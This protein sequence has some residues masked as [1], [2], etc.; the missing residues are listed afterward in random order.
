MLY[1]S[2]A[3][4]FGWQYGRRHLQT[5]G[6]RVWLY[7]HLIALVRARNEL[8]NDFGY[9]AL[10]K[11]FKNASKTGQLQTF[12]SEIICRLDGSER[13]TAER[14]VS[15]TLPN[16]AEPGRRG[17][18]DWLAGKK[19]VSPV[20]IAS[21]AFALSSLLREIKKPENIP[22]KALVEAHAYSLWNKLLTHQDFEPLASVIMA[23]VALSLSGFKQG[24]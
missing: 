17:F 4:C 22:A 1:S 23:D 16:S 19:K 11:I 20:I 2:F 9:G 24:L 7:D 12:L 10:G 8:N 15:K 21:Y 14:W 13:A 6:K 3:L 5:D 18:Q